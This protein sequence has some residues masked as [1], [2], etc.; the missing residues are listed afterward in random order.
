MVTASH[1]RALDRSWRLRIAPCTKALQRSTTVDGLEKMIRFWAV[2]T[3]I[4]LPLGLFSPAVQAATFKVLVVMS[5][6]ESN[7]WCKEIKQGIDS[8]LS[9]TSDI[10]YFYMDTKINIEGGPQKAEAAY[11]LFLQ[12]EPDGVITVDDNAQSLFVLPYLGKHHKTPVMF[13]GVNAEAEQYGFPTPTVSG[14]LERGHIRESIALAKQLVPSLKSITFLAKESPSGRALLRQVDRESATYLA[15]SSFHLIENIDQL[16]E[17]ED[18]LRN[19]SDAIYIDSLQGVKDSAGRPLS[20][21]EVIDI[22]AAR[23][24]KPVIGANQYHVE[25]GALCAVVKTGQE[26]GTTAAEMLHKAMLGTPVEQIPITQ[27]F[28]GKRVINVST[29]KALN[30]QVRPIVLLGATLIKS[31]E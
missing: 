6:E 24:R 25:Q 8:A 23:V 16:A 18:E 15:T 11:N 14:I 5:Y 7:P 27:N 26:Q 9:D 19:K 13:S 22:L 1:K 12:M 28:K 29:M 20:N 21:K 30:L 2:I 10:T 4:A 17:I 3:L 31:S